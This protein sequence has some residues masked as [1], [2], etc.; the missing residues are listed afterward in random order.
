[1]ALVDYLGWDVGGVHL[2]LS[3]LRPSAADGAMLCSLVEPFEIWRAPASLEGRL[4]S[5]L[6][7]SWAR[8]E[9]RGPPL[10]VAGHAVTMTA[11]LS[12]AFPGR[13]QGV[14][15]IVAA[16][17]AALAD[18]PMH[19]FDLE[20]RF[21]PPEEAMERPLTVAAANWLATACL[22]APLASPALLM[23]VGST[24]TDIV[25][26]ALGRPLPAGRTDTERLTSGE[27]VYTGLLRTP[28]S[29]LTSEVPLRGG[30]CR[31]STEYFAITADVYRVLG[32]IGDAGYTVATPDGRGK[33]IGD[34]LA[35]MA[36]LVCAD[37]GDLREDEVVAIARFLE[38]RQIE[39]IAAAVRQVLSRFREVRFGEAIVAG[40]GAFLAEAA[41][42]RA[43]LRSRRLAELLPGLGEQAWD[44]AAP[45][46]ALALLLAERAGGVRIPPP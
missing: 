19:V 4:R 35:R 17:V 23:D 7:D 20:G 10:A 42:A 24:T 44:V 13:P 46:A 11:E 15:A 31:V 14:R 25:P 8:A 2:K 30:L 5:M 27:L 22:A 45:S 26:L 21:V 1:M 36:R 29:S 16:C 41:A 33:G 18:A 3:I 28:P 32:R 40:A 9:L 39:R 12:D 34:S 6:N 38:E 43:G 37:P